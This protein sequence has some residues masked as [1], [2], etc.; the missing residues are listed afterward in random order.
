M[1]LR[2]HI[3]ALFILLVSM[4][5]AA[6][7]ESAIKPFTSG[8]Y[9]QILANNAGQPFLMVVWSLTCSSCLKDM[10]LLSN[11]HKERPGLKLVMLATD[12]FSE[13]PQIQKILEKHQLSDIENW[14]Y[15]NENTQKLQFEIDPGWYGEL[16]RTYFFDSVHQREGISGVLSKEDYEARFKKF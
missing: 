9:Q 8:S 1:T 11:I 13:T 3:T 5:G 12:E 2:K 10:E 15:A 6:L 14:V 7:A 4:T 16:P